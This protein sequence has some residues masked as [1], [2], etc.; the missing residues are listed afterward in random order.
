MFGENNSFGDIDK[1]RNNIQSARKLQGN[2]VFTLYNLGMAAA[3]I[4]DRLK[5][6]VSEVQ[7]I[8][9]DLKKSGV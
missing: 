4:A 8:L 1:I 9:L 7:Q 5:M 3:D 6:P 2:K